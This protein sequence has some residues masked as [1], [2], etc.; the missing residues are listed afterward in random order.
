[1]YNKQYSKQ[2]LNE[3]TELWLKDHDPN[4]SNPHRDKEEYPYL[5]E[6]QLKKRKLKECISLNE[7]YD[8]I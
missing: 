4:Y 1:M 2:E 7:E 5:S 8:N 3:L 6:R